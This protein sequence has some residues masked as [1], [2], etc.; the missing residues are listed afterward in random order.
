M[1]P[2]IRADLEHCSCNELGEPPLLLRE[3]VGVRGSL[4]KTSYKEDPSPVRLRVA[5]RRSG[6]R[7]LPQ[8]ERWSPWHRLG[9][10]FALSALALQAVTVTTSAETLRVGK[11]GREAFSFLPETIAFMRKNQRE[12]VA[13]AKEVMG[14]DEPTTHGI[15]AEL[16]PMFSDTDRF[17]PKALAVLS[18]S[19][20][21]M[22]TLR[23]EPDMSRLYTEAFLPSA[24]TTR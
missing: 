10:T 14:T 24:G 22:K 6:G 15:Y 8:G 13:I 12:T 5:K 23:E 21:E 7:P 4:R 17:D 1:S 2:G 18:K 19:F 11:A 16:M 3:R 9:A 20:V